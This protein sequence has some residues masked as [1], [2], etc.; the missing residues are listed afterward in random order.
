MIEC[1]L[2]QGWL[3]DLEQNLSG[4]WDPVD[5]RAARETVGHRAFAALAKA[6]ERLA[7]ALEAPNQPG[8]MASGL[9]PNPRAPP[10]WLVVRAVRA[11]RRNATVAESRTPSSARW[12][13]PAALVA[14]STRPSALWTEVDPWRSYRRA[15][16]VEWPTLVVTRPTSPSSSTAESPAE[17]AVVPRVGSLESPS[18]LRMTVV[19]LSRTTTPDLHPRT[20]KALVALDSPSAAFPEPAAPVPT[21]ARGFALASPSDFFRRS[22]AAASSSSLSASATPFAHAHPFPATSSAASAASTPFRVP[23][24]TASA[25]L[26]A[27]ASPSQLFGRAPDGASASRSRRPVGGDGAGQAHARSATDFAALASPFA[28]TN[29]ATT[30]GASRAPRSPRPTVRSMLAS[31]SR[32]FE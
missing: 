15:V 26:L 6:A 21:T 19:H 30:A 17:P 7:R 28:A 16:D 20:A 18:A 2:A 13:A 3:S 14:S 23:A 9:V 10:S 1:V 4:A 5:V 27:L 11:T 25:P 12:V 24:T 32:L 22:S 8:S 29:A 31:P